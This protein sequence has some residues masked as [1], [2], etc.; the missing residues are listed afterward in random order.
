MSQR[1][2]QN[3]LAK[4]FDDIPP[5]EE[6]AREMKFLLLYQNFVMTGSK[7]LPVNVIEVG[8]YH[9]SKAKPLYGDTLIYQDMACCCKSE[10]TN[11]IAVSCLGRC[12]LPKHRCLDREDIRPGP[13]PKN[14]GWLYTA[15]D[16]PEHQLRCGWRPGHISCSVLRRIE[17]HNCMKCG[18]CNPCASVCSKP[19]CFKSCCMPPKCVTVCPSTTCC[20]GPPCCQPLI[21][22][23]R[24]N[25]Q[26]SIVTKP[27]EIT[28]HPSGPYPLKYVLNTDFD[29]IKSDDKA[30]FSVEA[31]FNDYHF[32]YT[33][34]QSSFVLDFSPPEPKCYKPCPK[35]SS[36]CLTCQQAPAAP[37]PASSASPPASRK[38]SK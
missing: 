7:I 5:L 11:K 15:R 33:S 35:R 25:G 3:T 31:K 27:S 13:V 8:G 26:Y 1:N 10:K 38:N 36:V 20:K 4:Y 23:I 28:N 24:H 22:V 9:V 32:D 34:S 30:K 18:E 16:A 21:R 12:D 19:P 17:Q 14:M 37:A 6:L 29:D 2:N